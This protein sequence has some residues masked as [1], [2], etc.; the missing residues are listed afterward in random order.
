MERIF[1]V[2]ESYRS[3]TFDVKAPMASEPPCVLW[4]STISIAQSMSP[5]LPWQCEKKNSSASAAARMLK[6]TS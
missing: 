2:S 1:L 6:R 5:T 3:E 4:Y